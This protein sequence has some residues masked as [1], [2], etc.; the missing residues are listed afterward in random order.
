MSYDQTAADLLSENQELHGQIH[1]LVTERASDKF[2]INQQA[3][4]IAIGNEHHD[5]V[6][7]RLLDGW[8]PVTRTVGPPFWMQT[9]AHGKTRPDEMPDGEA[10]IIR[11]HTETKK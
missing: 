2:V 9:D 8:E 5:R 6:I 3:T 1:D 10:A 11:A 4:I 7:A